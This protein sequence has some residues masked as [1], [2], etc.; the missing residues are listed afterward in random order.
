MNE[1]G[2]VTLEDLE[3]DDQLILEPEIDEQEER[4]DIY[5]KSGGQQNSDKIDEK[6]NPKVKTPKKSKMKKEDLEEHFESKIQ[7]KIER[8]QTLAKSRLFKAS[9]S[10]IEPQLMR[11]RLGES[12][13][14]TN[15]NL[16]KSIIQLGGNGNDNL[17]E[18]TH[19]N[20][21]NGIDTRLQLIEFERDL[22][23]SLKQKF[24]EFLKDSSFEEIKEREKKK[25]EKQMSKCKK[26]RHLVKYFW[27]FFESKLEVVRGE[28][29]KVQAELSNTIIFY[30]LFI[31]YFIF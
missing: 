6:L 4:Y 9:K 26:I 23:I 25:T 30:I 29:K 17:G 5:S 19:A 20:L 3:N 14:I 2:P 18:N 13:V 27:K 24:W 8:R 12:K 16:V 11:S 15:R 10:M 31:Y 1:M 7:S 28:V 21:T 22:L